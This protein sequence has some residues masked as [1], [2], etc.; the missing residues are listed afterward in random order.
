MSLSIE[1]PESANNPF[2][3][4]CLDSLAQ[5]PAVVGQ[6]QRP[7]ALSDL[8]DRDSVPSADFAPPVRSESVARSLD[9]EMSAELPSQAN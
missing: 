8:V 9:Q 7:Q 4:T 3:E 5:E 1:M 2:A 6:A